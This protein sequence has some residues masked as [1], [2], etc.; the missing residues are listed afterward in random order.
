[1]TEPPNHYS[2]RKKPDQKRVH[3]TWFPYFKI[4]QNAN[5]SMETEGKDVVC[6]EGMVASEGIKGEWGNFG[7]M[8]DMFIIL[9]VVMILY[10]YT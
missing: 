3:T 2:E 7:R 10:L 1:M 8:M 9:T 5:Y 4:L 6:G